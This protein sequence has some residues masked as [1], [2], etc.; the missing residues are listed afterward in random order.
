MFAEDDEMLEESDEVVKYFTN[1]SESF[2]VLEF[3]M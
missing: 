1:P 2:S 3:H